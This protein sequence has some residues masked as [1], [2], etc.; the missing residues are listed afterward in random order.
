MTPAERYQ[1]VLEKI[2]RAAAA[3]G[4][5]REEIE[6]LAVSKKRSWQDIAVLYDLGQRCFGENR[7]DE[8]A[9]KSSQ[10]PSDC[11]WHFIGNLQRNKVK[12]AIALSSLIHS[13]DSLA[14]AEAISHHSLE[15]KATTA[16]LLEVN[17]SC[18]KSKHGLS[19][20]GWEAML[21]AVAALPGLELK[22][23]MT[24]APFTHDE[25]VLRR[26]F[27]SLRLLRDRLQQ[28]SAG[29]LTLPCLSMGMSNDFECAIREGATLVRIGSALFP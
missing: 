15:A 24:M 12:K 2:D 28:M 17:V 16:V 8:L 3:S 20:E 25:A 23:L 29:Q 27:A 21:E 22:G 5:K 7:I 1:A 9:S 13:V 6:L 19:P 4:R 11:L 18:E 14:L 26:C 10:A